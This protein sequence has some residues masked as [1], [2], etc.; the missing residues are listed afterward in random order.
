MRII[1]ISIGKIAPLF[2]IDHPDYKTVN[3]GIKKSVISS[4]DAP[5]PVQVSKMGIQGDE[6]ADFSVHGGMEKAI[7]AYPSEHYSFWNELLQ[8]ETKRT[9]DLHHGFLGENLTIEGLV[10]SD[11]WVGDIWQIGEVE[12]Q[13]VKLREPCFKFNARLGYKAAGKAM[14]QST[15][16]GWYLQVNA[17]GTIKAGD[18][19]QVTPGRRETSIEMQNAFLLRKDQQKELP[20]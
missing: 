10:E 16:S 17:P 18:A 13:V 14:V 15:H 3:S 4:L 7:Y 6:Q 1:S 19:I 8:R 2:G 12:L 11:V 5:N 20:L 9:E